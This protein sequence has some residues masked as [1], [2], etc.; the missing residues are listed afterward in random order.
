MRTRFYTYTLPLDQNTPKNLE[1]FQFLSDYVKQDG[2]IYSP[3]TPKNYT[4]YIPKSFLNLF[5]RRLKDF[6]KGL[7]FHAA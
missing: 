4:R 7:F 3:P 6:I 2:E 1:F 5:P